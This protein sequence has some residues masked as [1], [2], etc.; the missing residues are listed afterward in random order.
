MPSTAAYVPPPAHEVNRLMG[1]LETFANRT[2]RIPALIKAALIHYQFETIHPFLD[3]N[4]R[5]GRLLITTYL[6]DQAVLAQPILY[7]S[8]Y[9]EQNRQ[10]YYRSLAGVRSA[11]GLTRWLLF[12]LHGVEVTA[13]QG[14]DTFRR[15]IE[16]ERALPERL[17]SLGSR[18]VRAQTT[19]RYMLREPIVSTTDLVSLLGVTASTVYRL[20]NDLESLGLLRPVNSPGR[21]QYYAFTEYIDL[22][23]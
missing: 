10:E 21:T 12:F 22:F 2:D 9:L 11:E 20:I 6:M 5:V 18:A 3:G 19:L 17:A 4:G 14:V 7:I 23:R 8:A 15:I 13:R 16:L 1:D